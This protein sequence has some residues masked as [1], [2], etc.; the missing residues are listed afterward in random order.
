MNILYIIYS[1]GFFLWITK[2]VLFW[3]YLWQLKEYR[4]DRLL[5]HLKGT[6]QGKSI[7]LSPFL[8]INFLFIIGFTFVILNE[9]AILGWYN[10]LGG[11]FFIVE[12]LYFISQIIKN[13]FRRPT[14]TPKALIISLG[15]IFILSI[16]YSLPL[17]TPIAWLLLVQLLSPL[18]V[19]IF[20]FT[21][22]F[23]TELHKDYLIEKAK[24]KMRNQKN[25]LVIAV[26]GSYGKSSTKEYMAHVLSEKFS[27]VK[28][29]F[30]N[31]TPIAVAKTI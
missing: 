3:T 6:I 12:G 23:P 31:N 25:L 24:E 15:S 30:S 4:L 21:F 19:A 13:S 27:V 26:S 5:V 17:T 11:L 2:T 14:F 20:V 28:T 10:I 18:I 8:L 9:E 22:S 29:H 7:L 16:I 1:I